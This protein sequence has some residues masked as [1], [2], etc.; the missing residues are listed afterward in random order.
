M[1]KGSSPLKKYLILFG[2]ICFPIAVWFF[3]ITGKN[4]FTPLPF[5]GNYSVDSILVNGKYK[6]DT[7]YP[8]IPD[9]TMT[10][11]EGKTITQNDIK[12]KVYVADFFFASCP[13]FCPRMNSG[14]QAVYEKYKKVE[15]FLL[16]SYTVDPDHDTTAVLAKYAAKYGA[17]SKR[18]LFLRGDKKQIHDLS[19]SYLMLPPDTVKDVKQ[20]I[21]HSPYYVLVDKERHIRGIYDSTNPVMLDSLEGDINFLLHQYHTK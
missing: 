2:V 17:D 13:S 20:D 15:D 16:I 18:W 7:V 12:G 19:L 21:Q 8:S 4:N 11:Q 9:F 6:V 5:L 1:S 10:N 14:L 3:L